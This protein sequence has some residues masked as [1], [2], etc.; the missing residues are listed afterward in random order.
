MPKLE[1]AARTK[2]V[3]TKTTQ[4]VPVDESASQGLGGKPWPDYLEDL[5]QDD[6]EITTVKFY[7][8]EPKTNEGHI[9]KIMRDTVIVRGVA[10]ALTGIID[11]AWLAEKFGGGVYSIQI[12]SKTGVSFYKANIRIDGEPKLPQ[13]ENPAAPAPVAPQGSADAS[14]Q[15]LTEL[16]DK[17]IDR[18]SNLQQAPPPSAPSA[19]ENATVTMLTAAAA[20]AVKIAGSSARPHTEDSFD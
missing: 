12:R 13:R 17:T 14:I 20:E 4:V 3:E 2:T 10:T 19:A 7:R 6:R 16:L 1:D 18:L 5:S 8:M 11:E 9:A 15:R